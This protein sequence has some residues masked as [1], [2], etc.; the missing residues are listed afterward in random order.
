MGLVRII[1]ALAVLLG[2]AADQSIFGFRLPNPAFAVEAF[3]IL[4]GFYMALVLDRTYRGPGSYLA[5]MTNRALRLYPIYWVVL[6]ITIP[7]V[8][9][10]AHF[11]RLPP[12]RPEILW[13]ASF[14]FPQ[15]LN[16]AATLLLLPSHLLMLGQE[17]TY[18]FAIDPGGLYDIR[19]FAARQAASKNSLPLFAFLMVPQAWTLSF[20]LIFYAMAPFLVRQRS[21]WIIALTLLSLATR[22]WIYLQPTLEPFTAYT[23][24]F[25]PAE[26]WTF[27]AGVLAFRLYQ[28]IQARDLPAGRIAPLAAALPILALTYVYLPWMPAWLLLPL[29]ALLVPALFTTMGAIEQRP[30]W[31]RLARVDRLLGDL[32]YPVYISHILV[33]Q[34]LYTFMP[35]LTDRLGRGLTPAVIAIT[36]TASFALLRLV[37][38]PV[39]RIRARN[40]QFAI[41]PSNRAARRREERRKQTPARRKAPR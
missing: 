5:F 10:A 24:K 8:F 14:L 30:K 41:R 31:A 19:E 12:D 26:L 20:E 16:G 17:F 2:H 27:T 15:L 7:V 38:D 33:L 34:I 22:G 11:S 21:R 37:G 29:V 6:L 13:N 25:F 32:S 3:F 9:V 18:F 4:S 36:L 1:L 40:R 23:Y 28:T 35:G 39:E